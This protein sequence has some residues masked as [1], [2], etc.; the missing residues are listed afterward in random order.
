MSGRERERCSV[1]AEDSVATEEEDASVGGPLPMWADR[2]VDDG[3]CVVDEDGSRREW[4]I[5]AD[6]AEST[7]DEVLQSATA[8]SSTLRKD[9]DSCTVL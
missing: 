1:S 4:T 8:S 5:E 7:A 2:G 9:G 6:W 3:A